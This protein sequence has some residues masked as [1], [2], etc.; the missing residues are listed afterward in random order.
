MPDPRVLILRDPRE[1]A[2]KCSLSP[3]RGMS[4]IEF[5]EY[6]AE[7]TIDATDRVLLH[8]DG[9]ELSAD[10]GGG[11]L[12]LIDCSWRRVPSLRRTVLGDPVLRRLPHFET[13]YPRRSRVFED[14]DQ[15]LASVEAL[16]AALFIMGEC[17]PELLASYRW[18]DE[19][20]EL[21]PTLRPR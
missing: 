16:Y 4:G 1:S 20:L 7:R 15:G 17:R 12:F 11:G 10:D 13:A 21:N 19:F 2:K 5:V 6:R 3:L 18:A 9:D 8:P 14:P